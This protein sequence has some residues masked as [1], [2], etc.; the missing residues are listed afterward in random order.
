VGAGAQVHSHVHMGAGMCRH[1]ERWKQPQQ[2]SANSTDKIVPQIPEAGLGLSSLP[3]KT[4]ATYT[5]QAR[6]ASLILRNHVLCIRVCHSDLHRRRLCCA[7]RHLGKGARCSPL[8][9]G[10]RHAASLGWQDLAHAMAQPDPKAELS[11]S[12]CL[13]AWL[14][15]TGKESLV[16]LIRFNQPYN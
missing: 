1:M 5:S 16:Y 6:A 9:W 14:L 13:S 3:P 7:A 8:C 11:R 4:A 12:A 15:S 10:H 2:R